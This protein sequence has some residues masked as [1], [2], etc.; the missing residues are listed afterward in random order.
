[1]NSRETNS[2]RREAHA[3]QDAV[4]LKGVFRGSGR[5]W[6]A[7]ASRRFSGAV[8]IAVAAMLQSSTFAK[9]L[10]LKNAIV[11]TVAKGDIEN[12]QV[13]VTA[14]LSGMQAKSSVQI[15]DV[16]AIRAATFSR[17]IVAILT[18]RGCNSASWRAPRS[19]S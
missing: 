1:M 10:L 15:K 12:G 9:S 4:A 19:S 16:Q 18:K 5:F 17:D 14:S 11:H 6:S 8:F 3:L 7:C 2:K 13:L